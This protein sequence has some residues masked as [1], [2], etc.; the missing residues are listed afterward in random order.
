MKSVGEVKKGKSNGR[1]KNGKST[2]ETKKRES[3]GEAER[4]IVLTL[5]YDIGYPDWELENLLGKYSSQ[6]SL[7]LKSLAERGVVAKAK[8]RPSRN[9]KKKRNGN[10]KEYP[11]YL[12]KNLQA[13]EIVVNILTRGLNTDDAFDMIA[14]LV[15]S[16]YG[17]SIYVKFG[18]SAKEIVAN[19]ELAFSASIIDERNCLSSYLLSKY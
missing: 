2:E 16:P 11:Y 3:T 19:K 9:P 4:R 10:Y 7:L 18:E 15:T 8:G 6:V 12:A 14:V 5:L 17:E 13:F 1:A